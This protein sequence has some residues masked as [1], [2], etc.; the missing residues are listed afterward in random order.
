VSDVLVTCCGGGVGD[1][2]SVLLLLSST[3]A[4]DCMEVV[5]YIGM[6]SMVIY[7][8]R[9]LNGN[10]LFGLCALQYVFP[11]SVFIILSLRHPI[12][13]QYPILLPALPLLLSWAVLARLNCCCTLTCFP[14][15]GDS[16]AFAVTGLCGS[17]QQ[18]RQH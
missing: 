8:S 1:T 7:G 18:P 17:Q 13:E 9:S 14:N 10:V 3:R 16:R 6:A 5:F 2:A 11:A 4:S 12:H 15:L